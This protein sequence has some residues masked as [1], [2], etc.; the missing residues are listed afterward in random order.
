MHIP[1]L[2]CGFICGWQWG[3]L[4]GLIVPI[5]RSFIFGAP[6]FFPMA[7]CMAFELATYGAVCG[8]FNKIFPQKKKYIYCSLLIAMIIGRL[9]WGISMAIAMGFSGGSFGLK[10][11]IAGAITNALPGITAQIILVPLIVMAVNSS[12]IFKKLKD[13]NEYIK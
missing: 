2:L 9:I 13:E 3:C 5:S 1:V 10:A 8:L 11:F 7:V 4:I 12:N 6:Q